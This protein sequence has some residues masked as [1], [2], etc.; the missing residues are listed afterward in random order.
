MRYLWEST[1]DI[2]GVFK[3]RKNY[4]K[5]YEDIIYMYG[6]VLKAYTRTQQYFYYLTDIGMHETANYKIESGKE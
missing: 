2:I 5:N 1:A 6:I 4:R 3:Y